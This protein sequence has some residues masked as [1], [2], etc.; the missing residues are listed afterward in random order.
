MNDHDELISDASEVLEAEYRR[1]MCIE[2]QL[3]RFARAM[4]DI[5]APVPRDWA[6]QVDTERVSFSSLSPKA[7]DRLVCLMEDLAAHRPITVTVMRGGP[8][9]FDAGAPA[10][11]VAPPVV[12]SV[13]MVVPQ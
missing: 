12:S 3:R 1:A 13:H 11:P 9:L 10:G 5:G 6:S 4:A 7:F 2:P 8:T